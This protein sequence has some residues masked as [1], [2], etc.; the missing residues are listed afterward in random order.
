MKLITTVTAIAAALTV[1]VV[2]FPLT[3]VDASPN[4][5]ILAAIVCWLVL[6]PILTVITLILA[7]VTS[8][9]FVHRPATGSTGRGFTVAAWI[10]AAIAAAG[11]ASFVTSAFSGAGAIFYAF[12]ALAV[13]VFALASVVVVVTLRSRGTSRRPVADI[14]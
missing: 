9:K 1:V 12:V 13:L 6:T 7:T 4:D 8:V 5:A 10:V 3:T 11:A 2:A 14:A